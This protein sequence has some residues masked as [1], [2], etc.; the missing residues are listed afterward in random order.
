VEREFVRLMPELACARWEGMLSWLRRKTSPEAVT[1]ND[2]VDAFWRWFEEVA[3]RLY[4]AIEAG[5]CGTLTE[6]TSRKVNELQAGF[7]W[8]YGPG[9]AGKGHSLTISGEG[10]EQRQLLAQQCCALAPKIAGWT[11][12]ASRQA[13][14]IKGHVITMDGQRFDPK[15]IW[16]TPSVDAENQRIDITVWHPSW[17][18][19]DEKKRWTVVF[20]FLDEVLGEYG[21]QWWIGE[22]RFGSDRLV[23]SFPLEELAGY[24]A[25]ISQRNDWKKYPVGESWTLFEIKTTERDFP[26]SDTIT[27]TTTTVS[28]FRDYMEAEGELEDPLGDSGADYVYVSIARD[29]FPRGLETD[30]RGEIEEA[31]DRALKAGRCRGRHIGGALGSE[32]AYID[33]LLF[34]GARSLARVKE[35]LRKLGVPRGT[36]IEYF[37][38][39]K[40]AR[41]I[42]L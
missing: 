39:E 21:T 33:L 18:Q 42:A 2:R 27:Q 32:R 1:F 11:F 19:I 5:D 24:V 12:Y 37:A 35:T 13:G 20:L 25:E 4:A 9:E 10:V 3:P 14:P 26:R 40:R 8:V 31:I 29:F 36:M 7:A 16:V 22:I 34:D 28:L 15:E 38:R 6:E 23:G 30:K 41:R 17:G